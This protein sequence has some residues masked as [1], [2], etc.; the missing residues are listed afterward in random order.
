MN[1]V[2]RNLVV[3]AMLLAIGQ[4]C[5][6]RTDGPSGPMRVWVSV[7]PQATLVEQIGG[8]RVDVK[9]LASAGKDPH[10]F[11]PTPKQIMDVAQA[12]LLFTTGMPFETQLA[13]KIASG[14][15]R[16][17]VVDMTRGIECAGTHD[18][19]HGDSDHAPHACSRTDPHVWLSPPAL[20]I[21]AATIAEALS[22]A[23]PEG[24]A[25]YR[26]NLDRF[27]KQLDALDARV[28]RRLA[29][30]RGQTVYVYH[31]ALGHYCEAYGLIQKAVQLE[32][33]EPTPRQVHELIQQAKADGAKVIFVQRQFDP[34]SAQAVADALGGT[35]QPL[36]PL[37]PNVLEN[38]KRI[39][40]AIVAATT[41]RDKEEPRNTRNTQKEGVI[42][43]QDRQDGNARS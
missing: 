1:G 6:N 31:P 12:R 9:V 2:F 4:G 37:D 8:D 38:I 21:A 39:T 20:K 17:A 40:D 7:P 16:L 15:K 14:A 10:T 29:P 27:V 19:D 25:V 43:K 18:H 30:L 13:E 11:E 41:K 35:V 23:D 26:A 33:R 32:G 5:T 22:E 24:K 28:R 36:D 34:R 3:V 42:G